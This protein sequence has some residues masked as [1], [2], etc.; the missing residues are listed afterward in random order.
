MADSESTPKPK[1]LE[2]LF[3]DCRAATEGWLQSN[4][5]EGFNSS[6]AQAFATLAVAIAIRGLWPDQR[7]GSPMRRRSGES[8]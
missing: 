4:R 3:D 7:R 6:A 2:E 8:S 1:S 5:G